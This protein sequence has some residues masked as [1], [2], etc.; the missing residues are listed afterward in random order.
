MILH[1]FIKDY[2]L[3]FKEYREAA[4]RRS[5]SYI[6][7]LVSFDH[8]CAEKFPAAKAITQEMVNEWC[9]PRPTETNKSCI[10]RISA[11]KSFLKFLQER[12]LTS[13]YAPPF[14]KASK[15]TY[16]PHAFTQEELENFFN[17]CDN[18]KPMKGKRH[19]LQRLTL[20]VIFRLLYSSGMR[21]TEV[22][23]LKV[24]NIDLNTGV[25]AVKEG[26]GYSEHYVVLH[27]T[28]LDLLQNYNRCISEIM[29]DRTYFFPEIDDKPHK[30]GWISQHFR[31]IW[32]RCNKTKAWPYELRH[33][34]AIEN[35][36]S[37]KGVG[38]GIHEKLFTLS[39]SMGHA[40]MRCT[41]NYYA[42]TPAISDDL[43][44]ADT[45]L[46]EQII[47]DIDI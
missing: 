35:I 42:L 47:P 37:W 22:R 41:M 38:F 27:D 9:L 24:E 8:F 40:D 17:E 25:I 19:L 34:Y 36:N 26:K 5:N 30:S 21:T 18:I 33:H 12:G 15:S 7:M 39:R 20:P 32:K 2:I 29:P 43:M 3:E 44:T 28:T 1:S 11:I 10:G 46:Y 14:P 6:V 16:I 45:A 23:L 31:K 13:V 4:G